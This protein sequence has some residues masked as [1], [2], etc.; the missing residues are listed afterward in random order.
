MTLSTV[1]ITL[2]LLVLLPGVLFGVFWYSIVKRGWGSR[3]LLA[4]SIVILLS[5]LVIIL[6]WSTRDTSILVT[7]LVFSLLSGIVFFV[8]LKI[9]PHSNALIGQNQ[10]TQINWSSLSEEERN[11]HKQSAKLMI[12]DILLARFIQYIPLLIG[13]IILVLSR[14]T[15]SKVVTSLAVFIMG[16]TGILRIVLRP[17]HPSFRRYSS[18]RGTIGDIL[19][20]VFA[21]GLALYNLFAG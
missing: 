3:W 15:P 7:G 17:Q 4:S 6:W 2:C 19:V 5:L 20:T 1:I 9:S 16:F 8:Y 13:I 18:K 21:W 12:K 14:G 10:Q 11:T